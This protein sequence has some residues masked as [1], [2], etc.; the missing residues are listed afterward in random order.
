MNE[1]KEINELYEIIVLILVV[2]VCFYEHIVSVRG[3]LL[4]NES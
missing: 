1:I 3:A 4:K 2:L